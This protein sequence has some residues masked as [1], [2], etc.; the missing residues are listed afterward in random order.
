MSFCAGSC[1]DGRLTSAWNWC[2]QIE[3]KPYYHIFKVAG[4]AYSQQPSN[5]RIAAMACI[6]TT[7]STTLIDCLFL[8]DLSS[9]F[10]NACCAAATSWH[11]LSHC[12]VGIGFYSF[13]GDLGK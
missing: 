8:N 7:C 13:D 6:C 10:C 2:S 4:A 5:L 3:K 9:T 12:C 1:I 11:C